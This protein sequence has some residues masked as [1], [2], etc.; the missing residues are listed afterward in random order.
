LVGSGI[1]DAIFNNAILY[2]AVLMTDWIFGLLYLAA[3]YFSAT[4]ITGAALRLLRKEPTI[5][6]P[7]TAVRPAEQLVVTFENAMRT[8]FKG[9]TVVLAVFI[10]AGSIRLLILNF[11]GAQRPKAPLLRLSE[12]DQR[13]I[14]A[15][16]RNRVPTLRTS[17]PDPE[18]PSLKFIKKN[19]ARAASAAASNRDKPGPTAAPHPVADFSRRTQIAVW[20]ETLSPFLYHFPVGTEFE[21]RDRLFRKRPFDCFILRTSFGWAVFPG[22]IP[23]SLRDRQVVF[24]GWIEG[25]HPNGA[26]FGRVTQCI[27]IIP[28]L[29]GNRGLDYEHAATALP[30]A[31][32]IW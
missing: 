2:R 7:E 6:Q 31:D 10:L 13:E 4:L 24:V 22:K 9:V 20:C 26:R 17:L 16:L 14:I 3:F 27:A 8:G 12:G 29:E 1:G 30:R 23:Q 19:E 21:L 25:E 15:Q 32:D 11:G 28:V 18:T 5:S